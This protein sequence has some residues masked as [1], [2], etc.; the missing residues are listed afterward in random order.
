MIAIITSTIFPAP[1]TTTTSYRGSIDYQDRLMQTVET[2]KSL[3]DL[4][5]SAIY[6]F[7]NSGFN[8]EETVENQLSPAKIIKFNMFQFD[9][10][11]LSELYMLLHGL[12]VIPNDIPI[13]KISGRYILEQKLND[14]LLKK[15]DF[16]GKFNPDT[17]STRAYYFKTREAM[18]NVLYVA[19]NNMYA[20]KHKI[21]GFRSLFKVMQNAFFDNGQSS[22]Y[23]TTISIERGMFNAIKKLKLK[24]QHMPVIHVSGISGHADDNRKT[25]QE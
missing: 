18:Q 20:Y 6:L 13:L 16:A 10:K 5:F 21:V 2:I 11:G 4:Q 9:N 12:S 17:I 24:T 14:E 7:D 1:A 25:I 23:D 8:W 3:V 15:V 22:F 19:L